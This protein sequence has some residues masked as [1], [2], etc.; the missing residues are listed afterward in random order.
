MTEE[1]TLKEENAESSMSSK[2][3]A[4]ASNQ[5]KH[6]YKSPWFWAV[7]TAIV[8]LIAFLVWFL[9]VFR[10]AQVED[11][12]IADA[13]KSVERNWEEIVDEAESLTAKVDLASNVTDFTALQRDVDDVDRCH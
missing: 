6:W 2:K 10:P 11:E 13:K 4:P 3:N 8:L 7:A 9:G 12:R 5:K 1:I